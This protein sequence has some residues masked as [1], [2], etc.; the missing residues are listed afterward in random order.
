MVLTKED[1][2][3]NIVGDHV[4][5]KTTDGTVINLSPDAME[6]LNKDFEKIGQLKKERDELAEVRKFLAK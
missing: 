5:I 1:I 3:I 6:E 2:N 4:E